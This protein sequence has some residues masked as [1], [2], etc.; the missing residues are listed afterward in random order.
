MS[1]AADK[2]R[3]SSFRLP[4]DKPQDGLDAALVQSAERF[5]EQQHGRTGDRGSSDDQALTLTRRQVCHPLL[6]D[7]FE[8]EL[9][10][11]VIDVV[12]AQ[13]TSEAGG[14]GEQS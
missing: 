8:V 4:G 11:D 14:R 13:V 12:I 1:G 9:V 6:G 7:L 3:G 10:E 2:H 5:V